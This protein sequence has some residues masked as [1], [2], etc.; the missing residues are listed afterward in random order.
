MSK[1]MTDSNQKLGELFNP[2]QFTVK[3]L[4]MR[5]IPRCQFERYLAAKARSIDADTFT[6]EGWQVTLSKE[7]QESIGVFSLV[8]VDVTL[9]VKNDQF[10]DFLD[11]FR[12]NF[13]RGGG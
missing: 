13:L 9:A 12:K 10:D 5:G 2:D 3:K 1:T 11:T 8:A 7:R 4:N 6:G